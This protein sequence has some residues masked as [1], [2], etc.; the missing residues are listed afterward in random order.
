QVKRLGAGGYQR[1][2]GDTARLF[3]AVSEGGR[4]GGTS[5]VVARGVAVA[6]LSALGRDGGA[7][8][9]EPK[10]AMCVRMAKLNYHQCLASAGTHYEDIYC[11]GVHALS[12]T[13][14]CVL[15][16]TKPA[17]SRVAAR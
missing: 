6:A 13:G 10:S 5:P 7:L 9:S 8:M 2:A 11:L 15:D 3:A 4:R 12:E 14:Q 1:E 16:A 17:R